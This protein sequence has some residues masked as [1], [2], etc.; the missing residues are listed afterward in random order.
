MHKSYFSFMHSKLNG[1]HLLRT[2][3]DNFITERR[4]YESSALNIHVCIPL[5]GG[6]VVVTPAGCI[7]RCHNTPIQT[8]QHGHYVVLYGACNCEVLKELRPAEKTH[9]FIAHICIAD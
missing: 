9:I 5:L 7:L 1:C 8:A 4:F 3:F 6:S 2:C